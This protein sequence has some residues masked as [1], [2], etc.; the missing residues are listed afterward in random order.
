MMLIG[1][2]DA[3]DRKFP[4]RPA[5]RMVSV[6]DE[7]TRW[8]IGEEVPG[9]PRN[10]LARAGRE[11]TAQVIRRAYTPRQLEEWNSFR[12]STQGR[13]G[14]AVADVRSALLEQGAWLVD[15][16]TGGYWSWPLARVRLLADELQLRPAL[17]LAFN[18][19]YPN[20]AKELG[21]ISKVPGETSADAQFMESVAEAAG[22][23]ALVQAFMKR[24]PSTD[25]EAFAALQKNEVYRRWPALSKQLREY[26]LGKPVPSGFPGLVNKVSFTE[27]C[28]E[29]S[30][31]TCDTADTFAINLEQYKAR[32]S[33]AQS[34]F[35]DRTI[36]QLVKQSSE[37]GCP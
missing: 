17:D 36:Q 9:V 22:S 33:D 20:G 14:L 31:Q 26:Q 13:R 37:A 12:E 34:G 18:E 28:K 6:F 23:R 4:A 27:F 16:N 5:P 10:E 8:L 25:A 30:I 19:G 24:I 35:F 29:A 2:C 21:S 1:K 32:L 11:V 15:V 7:A 3:L